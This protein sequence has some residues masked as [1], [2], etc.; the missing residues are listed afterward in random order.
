MHGIIGLG[1]SQLYSRGEFQETLRER[2]RGLSGTFPE[3]L[4][5]SP[6]RT[7]GAQSGGLAHTERAEVS[8]T[9]A[10]ATPHV[11]CVVAVAGSDHP[12]G[13]KD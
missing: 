12:Q 8:C 10:S 5:E 11:S 4:P 13:P 3:F 1:G 6:S 9:N 7:G 2:F